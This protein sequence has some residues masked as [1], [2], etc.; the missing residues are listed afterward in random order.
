MGVHKLAESA[1]GSTIDLDAVYVAILFVL[2]L[3]TIG[4]VLAID[5]IGEGR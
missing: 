4:L 5:R 1:L 2:F 3:A